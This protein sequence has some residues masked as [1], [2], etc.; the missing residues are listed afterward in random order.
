MNKYIFRYILFIL[1]LLCLPGFA[2][3]QKTKKE[4]ENKKKKLQEDIEYPNKLLEKTTNSKESSL[5]VLMTVNRKI[6]LQEQVIETYTK[7]IEILQGQIKA[8]NDTINSM[9]IRL[10]DLKKE[11]ARMVVDAY[12]TEKGYNKLSFIFASKDFEQAALRMRYVQEYQEY[13]HRQALI[14]DSTS[15]E[16]SKKVARLQKKKDE[17][18]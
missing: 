1:V 14:I 16:V 9:E 2:M 7:E 3:A 18:T 15:K 17:K 6:S 4:L 8:A 11:Y 13:R 10:G 12:K 5:G